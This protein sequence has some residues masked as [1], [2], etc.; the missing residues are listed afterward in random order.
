M[1]SA[2]LQERLPAD[3]ANDGRA[4]LRLRGERAR[5]CRHRMAARFRARIISTSSGAICADGVESIY[6]LHRRGAAAGGRRS[7]ACLPSSYVKAR[8]PEWNR[9]FDAAFFGY[10]P[11]EAELMA[12]SCGCSTNARGKR[13]NRPGTTRTPIRDLSASMR[14][15]PRIW[16][17]SRFAGGLGGT[18]R[19]APCCSTIGNFQHAAIL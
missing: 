4:V 6:V 18:E 13:W 19:F 17:G 14:A 1:R 5:H 2:S 11:R 7:G 9:Q 12:R 8:H 16:N 3:Q 10:S 15:R